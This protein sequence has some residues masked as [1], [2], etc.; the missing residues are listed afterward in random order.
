MTKAADH[1]LA[2][3]KAFALIGKPVDDDNKTSSILPTARTRKALDELSRSTPQQLLED[4]VPL[5]PLLQDLFNWDGN[6]HVNKPLIRAFQ[7]AINTPMKYP[8]VVELSGFLAALAPHLEA[9]QIARMYSLV[10]EV[11]TAF[12]PAKY[13]IQLSNRLDT[14]FKGYSKDRIERLATSLW[15]QSHAGRW[16]NLAAGIDAEEQPEQVEDKTYQDIF[17]EISTTFTETNNQRELNNLVQGVQ[18]NP[19]Y[20]AI[21]SQTPPNKEVALLAE[22]YVSRLENG[23]FVHPDI[24]V[25]L[26]ALTWLAPHQRPESPVNGLLKTLITINENLGQDRRPPKKPR[27]FSELF[28]SIHLQAG[29]TK[30]FPFPQSIM[31]LQGKEV[32]KNAPIR[33]ILNK[34]ALAENAK[35]MGNCT[36]SFEGSMK[37]GKYVLLFVDDGEAQH[38]IALSLKNDRRWGLREI[39]AR[40]NQYSNINP[41][42]RKGIEKIISQLPPVDEAFMNY[43]DNK[44]NGDNPESQLYTYSLY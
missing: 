37:N 39:N 8:H 41:H 15:K 25:Y 43:L 16:W 14:V 20:Q 29:A 23:R 30:T 21:F 33:I 1:K 3:N 31:Q 35:Y 12:S 24:A 40:Y 27:E 2:I 44:A 26:S 34:I 10:N 13:T 32:I 36:L 38:N 42:I 7:E 18:W 28:P 17:K 6:N 9:D 22:K 19:H 5:R 11:T 4:E